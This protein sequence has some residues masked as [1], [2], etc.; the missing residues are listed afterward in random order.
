MAGEFIATHM[1]IFFL[2]AVLPDP[3]LL[4]HSLYPIVL[5]ISQHRE[6]SGPGLKRFESK[7]YGGHFLLTDVFLI[8]GMLWGKNP[9]F[10][11]MLYALVSAVQQL[12]TRQLNYSAST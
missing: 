1:D 5:F 2:P 7:Y 4:I 8:C 12:L 9:L 10:P 3:V 11:S 6:T